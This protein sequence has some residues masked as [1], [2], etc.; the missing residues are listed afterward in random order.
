MKIFRTP[1]VEEECFYMTCPFT[2]WQLGPR[3]VSLNQ[4]GGTTSPLDGVTI[5]LYSTKYFK[6]L[7][8]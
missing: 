2:G 3:A 7:N 8:F 4:S 5:F 6:Y 1:K